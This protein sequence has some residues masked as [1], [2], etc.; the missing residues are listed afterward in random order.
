MDARELVRMA[1]QIA[2]FFRPYSE[3]E[4][5]EGVATHLRNF[6]EPR[7]RDGLITAY[8]RDP[9]GFEPAVA[10]AIEKLAAPSDH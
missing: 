8:H 9:S 6:W 3:E 2:E 7:M 1:N 4:A 5:I 10:A